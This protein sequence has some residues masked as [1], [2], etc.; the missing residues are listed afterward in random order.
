MNRIA[1]VLASCCG[2]GFIP[3]APGTW[4]SICAALSAYYWNLPELYLFFVVCII[5]IVVGIAL[6]DSASRSINVHDPSW[7]VIDEWIGMWIAL[8]GISH[9]LYLY[10]LACVLFRFFDI[11]KPFPIAAIEK[12]PGGFGI[13][14]DDVFAGLI[15]CMLLHMKMVYLP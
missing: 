8:L 9:N 11:V 10:V 15:T 13:V 6:S 1:R 14:L 4:A 7:I 3:I 12:L 2:I 5:L